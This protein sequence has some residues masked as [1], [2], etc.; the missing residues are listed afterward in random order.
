MDQRFTFTSLL[1][2]SSN[3]IYFHNFGVAGYGIEQSFQ[4]WIE[5]SSLIPF[6]VTLYVFCANDLRNIYEAKIFDMDKMRQG[7]IENISNYHVPWHISILGS[8]NLTYLFL[9]A[10]GKGLTVLKNMSEH[11]ARSRDEFS[12]SLK[13]DFL[14]ASPSAETNLIV[15]HFVNVL[16]K[17]KQMVEE[18]GG[19]F[20]VVIP[21]RDVDEKVS[22]KLLPL[23]FQRV[24]LNS[25]DKIRG[26][27]SYPMEFK[28]DGHW[29]EYGNLGAAIEVNQ[30]FA[31]KLAPLGMKEFSEQFVSDG[32][33]RI[34]LIYSPR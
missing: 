24:P 20:V 22:R 1:N 8:L 3:D 31:S 30:Y 7:I 26:L 28:N 34:D 4:N 21:P 9:E 23:E 6:N 29:N 16:R 27:E 2:Q 12:E 15:E 13:D 11:R 32:I 17:W 18:K 14:S 19:K 33:K 25:L 5:K 10:Y